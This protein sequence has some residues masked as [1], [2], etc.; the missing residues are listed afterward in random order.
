MSEKLTICTRRLELIAATTELISAEI[1]DRNRFSELLDARIPGEGGDEAWPPESARDVVDLFAAQLKRDPDLAG[2]LNWYWVF[3]D[4][5]S[6]ERTL[7]G[8]GGFTSRP[9]RGT[10]AIGYSVLRQYQGKGYATEAVR[11]LVEWAFSHPEVHTV[12]AEVDTGNAR[13]IRVLEKGGFHRAGPGSEE[14]TWRWERKRLYCP[15]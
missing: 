2:W 9:V 5:K 12:I 10:V 4:E 8:N 3:I 1:A 13:S 6:G 11:A 14:G 7:I 15:E